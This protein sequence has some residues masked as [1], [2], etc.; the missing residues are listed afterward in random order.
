MSSYDRDAKTPE[1][2]SRWT[3]A[4]D[5]PNYPFGAREDVEVIEVTWNGEEWWVKTRGPRGEFFT[6]LDVFWECVTP[7]AARSP[8]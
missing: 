1:V 7:P 4:S 6:D 3:W 5:Q 8:R 2:G